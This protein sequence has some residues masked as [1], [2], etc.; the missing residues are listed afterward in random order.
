MRLHRSQTNE[1]AYIPTLVIWIYWYFIRTDSNLEIEVNLD[2]SNI[3]S[4]LPFEIVYVAS[5]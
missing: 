4:Y 3:Q 5:F 1:Y 2:N